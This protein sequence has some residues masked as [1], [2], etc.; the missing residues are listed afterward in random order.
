MGE[1]NYQSLVVFPTH[2]SQTCNELTLCVFGNSLLCLAT[3]N[4]TSSC[5]ICFFIYR[6]LVFD[7]A[8]KG[9]LDFAAF[10]PNTSCCAI[11]SFQFLFLVCSVT[12]SI[13]LFSM[14]RKFQLIFSLDAN[15]HFHLSFH[16]FPHL[17]ILQLPQFDL[18]FSRTF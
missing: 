3:G 10:S 8:S 6:G 1:K 2:L 12:S 16:P 11:Y 18:S 15:F 14:Y 9:P 13:H 4:I 5:F 7:L 17:F